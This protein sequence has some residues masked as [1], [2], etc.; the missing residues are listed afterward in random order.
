[1]DISVIFKME[2]VFEH[3]FKMHADFWGKVS[4]ISGTAIQNCMLPLLHSW[5]TTCHMLCHVL[6]ALSTVAHQNNFIIAFGRWSNK[7]TNWKVTLNLLCFRDSF[8]N[9]R[10]KKCD[11]VYYQLWILS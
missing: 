4:V 8:K 7:I 6:W 3:L 9:L 10:K 1:M 11:Q 5:H 2:N